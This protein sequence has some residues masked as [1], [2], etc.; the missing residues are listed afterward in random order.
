MEC[1]KRKKSECDMILLK[2]KFALAIWGS[3]DRNYTINIPK[4][5]F[6]IVKF[7]KSRV[8]STAIKS[9]NVICG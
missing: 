9:Y 5:G 2:K 4:L 8:M 3:I 7:I 6:G 1:K